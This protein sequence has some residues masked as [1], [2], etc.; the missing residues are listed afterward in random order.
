MKGL[1]ESKARLS[2]RLEV[3][4]KTVSK[5]NWPGVHR[6]WGWGQVK[7]PEPGRGLCGFNILQ[8]PKEGPFL[9]SMFKCTKGRG[10]EG[11]VA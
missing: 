10:K 8:V 3:T 9:I 7:L 6:G 5:V 11:A 4:C 1:G 2:S